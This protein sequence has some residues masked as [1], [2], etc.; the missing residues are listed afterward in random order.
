MS[1]ASWGYT[2]E[3]GL[4]AVLGGGDID[5]INCAEGA[6]SPSEMKDYIRQAPREKDVSYS[7]EARRFAKVILETVE[8]DE[9]A[10]QRFLNDRKKFSYELLEGKDFDLTGFM[11]GWAFN[12]VGYVLGVP[13][14]G[15]PAIVNIGN[16]Y[17]KA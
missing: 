4:K 9:E 8:T 7:D 6:M 2:A 11:T 1:D 12:A 5:K 17:G 15:N 16:K 3:Q 10:R 13:P 14:A